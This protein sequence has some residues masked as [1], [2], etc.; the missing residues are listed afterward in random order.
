MPRDYVESVRWFTLAAEQGST[1]SQFNLAVGYKNG[2]GVK[3]DL[4]RAYMWFKIAT[5]LGD[6][7]AAES[8]EDLSAEMSKNQVAEA[9]RL[10][11]ECI[12][13]NFKKCD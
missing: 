7:D 5:G 11:Q 1:E 10:A 6:K 9:Q 13:R 4:V 2:L 12:K 8:L 3:K